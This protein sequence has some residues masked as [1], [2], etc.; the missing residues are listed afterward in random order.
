MRD[1]T[2]RRLEDV[3]DAFGGRYHGAMRF[4]GTAQQLFGKTGVYDRII[5]KAGPGVSATQLRDRVATMLPPG[6]EAVTAASASASAAQQINSQ[7]SILRDFFLGIDAGVEERDCQLQRPPI[8]LHRI[9]DNLP[10]GIERPN[11][12]VVLRQLSLRAE[13]RGCNVGGVCC[14]PETKPA[15]GR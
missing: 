7:L 11:L 14:W 9:L 3:P 5:V 6:L 15:R 13:E 10:L 2:I 4:L 12:K 8:V 1:Y